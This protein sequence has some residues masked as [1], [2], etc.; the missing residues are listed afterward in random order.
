MC[1]NEAVKNHIQGV[2]THLVNGHI[3]CALF[4]CTLNTTHPV[5]VYGLSVRGNGTA[6]N[7]VPHLAPYC[8]ENKI[9]RMILCYLGKHHDTHNALLMDTF[10]PNLIKGL[11][12]LHL[13]YLTTE[14]IPERDRHVQFISSTIRPITR[15]WFKPD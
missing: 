7:H 8:V 3:N 13:T 10:F 12:V 5:I 6:H 15:N 9:I 2:G 11:V 1:V 4:L 14:L